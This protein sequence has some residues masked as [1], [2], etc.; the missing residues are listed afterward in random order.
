MQSLLLK[1]TIHYLMSLNDERD[2]IHVQRHLPVIKLLTKIC[3]KLDI[4]Y[5]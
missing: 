3:V 2:K 1:E 5:F 4:N